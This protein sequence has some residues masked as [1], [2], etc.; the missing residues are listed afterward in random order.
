MRDKEERTVTN[1]S[2]AIL[3]NLTDEDESRL[4]PYLRAL[5]ELSLSSPAVLETQAD[6]VHRF[7]MQNVVYKESPSADVSVPAHSSGDGHH[8]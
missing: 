6:E 8:S 3:N 7:V 5:S 2:Q 4:L 1:D